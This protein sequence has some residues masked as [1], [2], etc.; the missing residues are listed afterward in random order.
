[1]SIWVVLKTGWDRFMQF[2]VLFIHI[3]IAFLVYFTRDTND[4]MIGGVDQ[5]ERKGSYVFPH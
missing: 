3:N 2:F 5:R 4:N 1:M